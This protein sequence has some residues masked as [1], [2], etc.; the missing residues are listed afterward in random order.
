MYSNAEEIITYDFESDRYG[1]LDK[2]FISRL[3][4][5]SNNFKII[6]FEVCNKGYSFVYKKNL[7]ISLN[8]N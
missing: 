8:F 7:F 3:N 6:D 1:F 2:E 4:T 5:N